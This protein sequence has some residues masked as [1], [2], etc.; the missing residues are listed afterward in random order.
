MRPTRNRTLSAA[1]AGAGFVVLSLAP[2]PAL[3]DGSIVVRNFVL[4]HGIQDREPISETESFN[5][6]DGKAYAFARIQ[7]T[8]EPTTVRF[9][10]EIDDA[11]HAT[12]PVNIGASQGWRTWSTAQL[13]SG[14]WR[15]KLLDAQ[16]EILLEKAFKV[17]PNSGAP[18]AG[19]RDEMRGPE[20]SAVSDDI[21]ASLTFP[22][23]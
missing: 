12:V 10:W 13:R 16:G 19:V 18:V 2:L 8:G 20:D 15:V 23:R 7:N 14:N 5:V 9:V 3:A 17:E 6:E 21:P 4:S 22:I 11:T 1:L